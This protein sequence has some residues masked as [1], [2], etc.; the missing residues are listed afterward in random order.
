MTEEEGNSASSP[1]ELR[2]PMRAVVLVTTALILG[3]LAFLY[4]ETYKMQPPYE[5]G[6]PG[7][8]FFPRL[9][10]GFSIIWALISLGRG[11]FLPQA[12]QA[13]GG[14]EPYLQAHWVEFA[15]VIAL[16]YIYAVL[17]EPIGFEITTIVFM[18]CLLVPRMRAES[19][20]REALLLGFVL[21]LVTMIV[22]YLGLV[23]MLNIP[24]P[25][26]FLPIYI[27]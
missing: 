22:L 5:P 8:A 23:P 6:Y 16:V 17:L 12:A 4:Y 11:F 15:S 18:M 1:Y 27:L 24:L 14:E 7:D 2:V 20:L 10:L 26:K 9:A 21:S 13:R 3:G 25:L 19:V